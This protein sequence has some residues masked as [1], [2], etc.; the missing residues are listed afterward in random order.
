[1][2]AF[3]ELQTRVAGD[4]ALQE[5]LQAAEDEESFIRTVEALAGELGF[6]L[7]FDE[8]RAGIEAST[9]AAKVTE[10]SD[11]DLANVA[12]GG[13]LTGAA[14]SYLC[15]YGGNYTFRWATANC[16]TGT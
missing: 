11:Q 2:T 1:M 3:E 13:V 12:G 8:I 5:R 15:F 4:A 7:H 16:I 9:A 10:L 6:D 14:V